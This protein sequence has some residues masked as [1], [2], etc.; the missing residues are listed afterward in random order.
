MSPSDEDSSTKSILSSELPLII[1]DHADWNDILRTIKEVKATQVWIT[2]GREDALIHACRQ[3]G[4]DAKALSL[5]GYE[6][7]TE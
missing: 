5:I 4:L 7:E 2:H 1:S 6:D 3:M